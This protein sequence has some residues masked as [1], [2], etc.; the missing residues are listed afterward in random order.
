MYV[1]F[2]VRDRILIVDSAAAGCPALWST[3]WSRR[4]PVSRSS[5]TG[6]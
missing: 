4:T 3:G 5:S 2:D 1:E 6:W